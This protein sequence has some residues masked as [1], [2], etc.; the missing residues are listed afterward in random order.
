MLVKEASTHVTKSIE[1]IQ[2]FENSVE[3]DIP[4]GYLR[5]ELSTKGLLGAPKVFHVRNFDTKEIVELSITADTE[6]PLKLA[7]ILDRLIFEDD[8]FI[9]EFH[10]NEVIELIVKLF[11]IFYDTTIELDFPWDDSDIEFLLENNKGDLADSLKAGSWQPK[12]FVD[13][14]KL[15]FY[16]VDESTLKKHVELTSRKTNFKVKFSYPKYGDAVVIKKYLSTSFKESTNEIKDIL[17]R[18]EIRKKVFTDAET[19]HTEINARLLPFIS[20]EELD[21]YTEYEM[22][23]ALFA[24]DLVRA[25]HLESFDGKDLS[26]TSLSEK[27][28]FIA[29][30][31]ISH[32]V[33]QTIEKEFKQMEFGI[34]PEL[35]VLNPI[36]KVPCKR[37][38]L[39]R[40]LDLL[41]TFK[42]FES[43]EYD[44]GYE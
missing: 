21:L 26:K 11:A 10:E 43:D 29:D 25:L 3:K 1:K 33:T 34:N 42:T 17:K 19:S 7:N 4:V 28:P 27:I 41:Q 6:L 8:V 35:E 38:F 22:E 9:N 31:R 36:T 12:A 13:L 44:V 39:F 40:I 23:K 37:R 16:N 32:T 2:S 30:P 14:A 24:V 20:K 15:D 18:L 5:M